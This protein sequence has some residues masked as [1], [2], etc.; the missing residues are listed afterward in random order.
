MTNGA[1]VRSPYEPDDEPTGIAGSRSW[2]FGVSSQR[3]PQAPARLSPMLAR[4]GE[5]P[6]RNGRYAYEFKW[7]GVRAIVHSD[8]GLLRVTSRNGTDLTA[9]FPEISPVPRPLLVRNAVLDGELVAIDPMSGRPDFG[10]LQRRLN[11]TTAHAV[12]QRAAEVP[13]IFFAFDLLWLDGHDI[14]GET[15]ERRRAQLLALD[16]NGA[17]WSTPK[18]HLGDPAPILAASREH[19]L[20]GIMAK[21]LDSRY[22]PGKRTDSWIKI[23]NRQRQEF[24]VC[25]WTAGKGARAGTIGS[26]LL[27]HYEETDRGRVLRYAGRVG[28]G[29]SDPLLERMRL[30]LAPLETSDAAFDAPAEVRAD[31]RFV[32][33]VLVVEVEFA[34]WTR[35]GR[36]RQASFKG[37]R[38]DKDPSEVVREDLSAVA[39]G[40]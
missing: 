36:V 40:A 39:G 1:P 33:P 9:T 21:R 35:E 11:L 3:T 32:R 12:R 6:E 31:S 10:L 16:L 5:P 14:M 24:V 19:G 34:E 17:S 2:D 38:T 30:L 29:F 13:V 26:L 27:G 4:S 25:G 23:K 8:H 20:E 15:Y 28:S 18:H 7:D 37:M 22:V